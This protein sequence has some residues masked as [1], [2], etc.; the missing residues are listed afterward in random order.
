MS[1]RL[2]A[3]LALLGLLS[4]A[5]PLWGLPSCGTPGTITTVTAPDG[6]YLAAF[7]DY[8][9]YPP[10]PLTLGPDGDVYDLVASPDYRSYYPQ[11]LALGPQ[12]RVYVADQTIIYRLEADGTATR[13]AG[14]PQYSFLEGD[15]A[16]RRPPLLQ[17]T[18]V[19]E[20]MVAALDARIAPGAMA[21]DRQ[22]RLYFVDYVNREQFLRARIARLEA[23][24]QVVTF[25]G[26]AEFGYINSLVFDREGNLLAAGAGRIRRIDTQGEVTPLLEPPGVGAMTVDAQGMLYFSTHQQVFRRQADGTLEVVAGAAW[27]DEEAKRVAAKEWWGYQGKFRWIRGTF[28]RK[29]GP[30]TEAP[31]YISFSDIAIDTQGILYIANT[32]A[33]LIH[34]V[35]P[36]GILETIAG[37]GKEYTT[38]EGCVAAEKRIAADKSLS[39]NLCL[40]NIGDGG[41][42][43]EAPIWWPFRL[44]ITP[45]DELLVAMDVVGFM[46][47]GGEFSHLRRICRVSEWGVPTAVE[48][49]EE[50]ASANLAEEALSALRLFPNPF[51]A[52]VTI[53]FDLTHSASVGVRIYNELGQQVRVLAAEGV[54]P[55]GSYQFVWDGRDQA[56]QFQASGTYLLVLSVDGASET[57]KLTLLH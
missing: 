56:G 7:S 52:A 32:G 6:D 36:D 8:T 25:A 46:W 24:G 45:E 39:T 48:T 42:A 21:F 35:R 18:N 23:D 57:H 55:A 29:G 26:P 34:R 22:G 37:N 49:V 12:G 41:P 47:G 1:T 44:L 50:Q 40:N 20:A 15:A 43:L 13:I 4:L 5:A 38:V 3:V 51:N 17:R 27:D 10:K 11:A 54:R 16:S 33:H 30:A 9:I 19:V 28:V 31:L 2:Y 14:V 53:A